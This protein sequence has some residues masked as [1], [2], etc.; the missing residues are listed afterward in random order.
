MQKQ[1]KDNCESFFTNSFFLKQWEKSS[2]SLTIVFHKSFTC[3]IFSFFSSTV[4][5]SLTVANISE[6][7]RCAELKVAN[8]GRDATFAESVVV[9][10]S[11][12]CST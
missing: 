7:N 8:S 1:F 9:Q 12:H 11:E 3:Y 2:I 4:K 5:Y 6:G 10:L